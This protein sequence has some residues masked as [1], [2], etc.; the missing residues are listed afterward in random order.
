MHR[1]YTSFSGRFEPVLAVGQAGEVEAGYAEIF[2]VVVFCS[3]GHTVFQVPGWL[4]EADQGISWEEILKAAGRGIY[5][6]I[7]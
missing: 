3:A 7:A 1:R 5:P 2:R 4:N 6:K